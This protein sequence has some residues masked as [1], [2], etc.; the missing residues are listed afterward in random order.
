MFVFP[1]IVLSSSFENMQ[2]PHGRQWQFIISYAFDAA[3]KGMRLRTSSGASRTPRGNAGRIYSQDLLT[4]CRKSGLEFHWVSVRHLHWVHQKY[5]IYNVG[6][7]E[8][9]YFTM[10]R[11]VGYSWICVYSNG[12]VEMLDV[13]IFI[14]KLLR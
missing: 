2:A 6:E 4:T 7:E 5:C 14:N 12:F 3:S 10:E 8:E 13:Q 9:F 1:S 11:C